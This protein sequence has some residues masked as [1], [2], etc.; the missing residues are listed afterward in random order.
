MCPSCYD[1]QAYDPCS[2]PPAK[3]FPQPSKVADWPTVVA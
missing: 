2:E 3:G 1:S